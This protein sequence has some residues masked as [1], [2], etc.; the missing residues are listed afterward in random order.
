MKKTTKFLAI[1]TLFIAGLS[2][3]SCKKCVEC[4]GKFGG[5]TISN[6]ECYD[7]PKEMKEEKKKADQN[8][9]DAMKQNPDVTCS[10]KA[11]SEK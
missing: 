10:C 2:F 4:T 5:L 6:T 8:C 3:T 1:A 7:S 11:V 9:E